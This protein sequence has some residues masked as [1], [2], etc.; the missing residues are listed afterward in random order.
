MW[1]KIEN[2]YVEYRGIN[3][4]IRFVPGCGEYGID[5]W[6]LWVLGAHE[7]HVLCKQNEKA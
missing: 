4:R 7:K 6:I 1:N 2:V 5:N 3:L